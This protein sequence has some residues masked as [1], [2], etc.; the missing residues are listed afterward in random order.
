[1]HTSWKPLLGRWLAEFLIAVARDD[2]LDVNL[3]QV[4][5]MHGYN[6]RA[7]FWPIFIDQ[8]RRDLVRELERMDTYDLNDDWQGWVEARKIWITET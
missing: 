2:S 8:S 6:C 5:D 3:I 7:A 4:L 1:M